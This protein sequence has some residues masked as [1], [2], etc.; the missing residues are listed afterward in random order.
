MTADLGSGLRFAAQPVVSVFV[1]GLPAR[2]PEWRAVIT[3]H[4]SRR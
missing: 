1:P 4:G 3:S 2:A